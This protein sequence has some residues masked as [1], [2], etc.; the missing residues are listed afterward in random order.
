MTDAHWEQIIV[1]MGYTAEWARHLS[2]Q[3]EDESG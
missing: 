1:G 3:K 2:K